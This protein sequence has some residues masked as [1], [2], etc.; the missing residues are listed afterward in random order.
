MVILNNPSKKEFWIDSASHTVY[1]DFDSYGTGAFVTNTNW[2]ITLSG[3]GSPSSTIVTS[4]NAGGSSDELRLVAA[5]NNY[6]QSVTA[7][8]TSKLLPSNKSIHIKGYTSFAA[9]MLNG[10]SSATLTFNGSTVTIVSGTTTTAIFDITIVALTGDVYDVYLGGKK[11]IN[12]SST[13]SPQVTITAS[14]GSSAAGG[15]S[16]TIYIDDVVY[17]K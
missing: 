2:T 9:S 6:P 10:S 16:G 17:S 14:C 1:D 8:A 12:A 5:T 7:V 3:V 4:T 13:V 15:Y 11:V